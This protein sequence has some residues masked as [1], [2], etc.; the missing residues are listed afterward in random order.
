MNSAW[1]AR[2]YSNLRRDRRTAPLSILPRQARQVLIEALNDAGEKRRA[3]LVR[4]ACKKAQSIVRRIH[5][6]SPAHDKGER[7]RTAK[8]G[9][10][11]S[12]WNVWRLCAPEV[13]A[14]L[15][16]QNEFPKAIRVKTHMETRR[17]RRLN[18]GPLCQH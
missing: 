4:A 12:G 9:R 11:K 14:D 2:V 3:Y 10:G 13:D 1:D 7:T 16:A 17:W 5:K 8:V 15:F 6:R 18:V